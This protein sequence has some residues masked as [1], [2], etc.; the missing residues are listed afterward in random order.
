MPIRLKNINNLYILDHDTKAQIFNSFFAV[1]LL[2][3]VDM[4]F[5]KFAQSDLWQIACHFL[6]KSIIRRRSGQRRLTRNRSAVLTQGTAAV[7]S[8][9]TFSTLSIAA[10]SDSCK[11]LNCIDSTPLRSTMISQ[12]PRV[13][14]YVIASLAFIDALAGHQENDHK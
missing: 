13:Q 14:V 9:W 4:H 7:A 5:Q 11:I 2:D 6:E 10:G 12:D 1:P 8:N 3:W